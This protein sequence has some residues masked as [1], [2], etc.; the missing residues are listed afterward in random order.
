MIGSHRRAVPDGKGF[1]HWLTQLPLALDKPWIGYGA[2]LALSLVAALMRELVGP[3]LPRGFPFVTFFPAV[4]LTA[5]L[6][7]IGPGIFAAI[8]SGLAAWYWFVPPTPGFDFSFGT[9]VAM[10]FYAGVVAVDVALV[11]WMQLANERLVKERE[12]G[13]ELVRHRELL[14]SELQHRVG[15]NLQMAAS[16]LNLQQRKLAEPVAR[17]ALEEAAQRLAMIGRVQRQLYDPTGAQLDLLTFLEQLVRDVISS[18][19]RD[20]IGLHFDGAPGLQLPP[21]S[22]IPTALIVA[23]V[24]SNA[25][26]HGFAGRTAGSIA[27]NVQ[28][29]DGRVLISVEDDGAGLPAGFD[30]NGSSSLGLRISRAMA[31]SLQ[32]RFTLGPA[33]AGG[34]RAVIDLPYAQVV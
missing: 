29:R 11:H 5:F 1:Q 8:L 4:I 31:E 33:S 26:E 2:A 3:M 25:M 20:G 34:A 28:Q 27:V 7:G 15:N 10:F 19:G 32:G 21:D 22:A 24:V 14:F 12:R 9:L 16:M 6:F 13:L 30:V 23:E 17:A 18:S